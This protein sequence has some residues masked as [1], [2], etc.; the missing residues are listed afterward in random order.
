MNFD[1]IWFPSADLPPYKCMGNTIGQRWWAWDKGEHNI[2]KTATANVARNY[3]KR[4]LT[5]PKVFCGG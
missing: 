1:N 3:S 2:A 5:D 4:F